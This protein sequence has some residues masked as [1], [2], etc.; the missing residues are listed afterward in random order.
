MTRLTLLLAVALAL[1]C[2]TGGAV[3]VHAQV[4]ASAAALSCGRPHV[5]K[6]GGRPATSTG[7]AG[8]Q[9]Y[10]TCP[11][12]A[13]APAHEVACPAASAAACTPTTPKASPEVGGAPKVTPAPA[14]ASAAAPLQSARSLVLAITCIVALLLSVLGLWLIG[15]ALDPGLLRFKTLPEPAPA[16]APEGFTF[17]RHWGS[18]GGESTGWNMSPRLVR[19]VS[20]TLL[21]AV[22]GWLVL[23][24]L[25]ATD[26][27]P[28]TR[29]EAAA[30]TKAAPRAGVE[31]K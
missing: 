10:V 6:L 26:P 28:K 21:A 31:P 22:G 2:A 30:E 25:A 7:D 5:N 29:S 12:T 13:P 3:E 23:Q 4:A 1:A 19:L 24:L 17:R 20:G 11:V 9:V 16:R 18:F 8:V 27:T 15:T 14:P